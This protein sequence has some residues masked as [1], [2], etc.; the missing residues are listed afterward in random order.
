M[1]MFE[2]IYAFKE[3][4]VRNK[5]RITIPH[6]AKSLIIVASN[7]SPTRIMWLEEKT[8]RE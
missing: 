8:Q 1:G 3:E 7:T 4:V 6:N 5:D 2:S